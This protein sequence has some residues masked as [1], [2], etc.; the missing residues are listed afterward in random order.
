M[1]VNYGKQ[2]DF[3]L[4]SVYGNWIP[5][6]RWGKGKEIEDLDGISTQ[7]V[8]LNISAKA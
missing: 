8:A 1:E 7:K 4:A 6:Y 5:A 3:L 2:T